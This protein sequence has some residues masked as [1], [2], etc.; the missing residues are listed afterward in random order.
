MIIVGKPAPEFKAQAYFPQEKHFDVVKSE[1]YRGKWLIVLF[2]PADFTF[3]CPTELSA[4]GANKKLFDE[5]N[6]D[7]V[8]ISTDKVYAHMIWS[9]TSPAVKKFKYPMLSDP[10][11]EISKA[12]DVYVEDEGLSLRGVFVIDPE[13]IVQTAT[14]HN[15][16]IGRSSLEI[17]RQVF[18]AK[19]ASEHPGKG[20]PANWEPGDAAID[21]GFDM[22]GQI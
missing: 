14:V 11:G 15:L 3:S 8:A 13:G 18:A 21:T 16:A 4:V 1:D 20:I 5:N 9:K 17:E 10:T 6:I 7:L 19:Y 22:V 12:F 2:Y